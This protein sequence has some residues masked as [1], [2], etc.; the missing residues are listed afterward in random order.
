[1]GM[2]FLLFQHL[3]DRVQRDNVALRQIKLRF[4]CRFAHQVDAGAFHLLPRL[5]I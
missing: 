4:F 5:S 2:S 1:M 3:L